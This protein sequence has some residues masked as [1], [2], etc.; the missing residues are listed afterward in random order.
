VTLRDVRVP[1]MAMAAGKDLPAEVRTAAF[2]FGRRLGDPAFRK[3][4]RDHGWRGGDVIVTV[5]EELVDSAM[6]RALKTTKPPVLVALHRQGGFS[7]LTLRPRS[8]W[9]TV[10]RRLI[11]HQTP[12]P[13]AVDENLTM[14]L[15]FDQLRRDSER[16]PQPTP[17][18]T[19][20]T[21]DHAAVF[22]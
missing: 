22:H 8:R 19:V 6:T 14:G 20:K 18:F 15:L 3:K 21:M 7:F 13:L 1:N 4:L 9:R 5:P 16:A 2:V 10:L 17:W 11:A 12:R